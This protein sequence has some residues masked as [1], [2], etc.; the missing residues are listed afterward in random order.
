MSTTILNN[1]ETLKMK[2]RHYSRGMENGKEGTQRKQ[3]QGAKEN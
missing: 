1:S 2:H 3:N